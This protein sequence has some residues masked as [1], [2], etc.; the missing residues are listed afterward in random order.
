LRRI[1]DRD[2]DRRGVGDRTE[3]AH[4]VGLAQGPRRRRLQDGPV[5]PRRSRGLDELDLH[6]GRLAKHRDRNRHS[7]AHVLKQPLHHLPP[8]GGR[9][10]ADLGGQAECCHPMRAGGD[11]GFRL[12]PHG[13]AV[14]PAGGIE[15]GV[16]NGIDAREGRASLRCRHPL[17]PTALD[18][19]PSPWADTARDGHRSGWEQDRIYD[20]FPRFLL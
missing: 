20:H 8:L 6:G 11:T 13:V 19:H 15:K 14:E 5:R 12:E 4:E 9:Q 1:L 16:E 7:A 17:L 18:Q 2:R 3:E 10:L